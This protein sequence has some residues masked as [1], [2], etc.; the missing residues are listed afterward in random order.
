MHGKKTHAGG[1]SSEP[2]PLCSRDQVGV[3]EL[4]GQGGSLD[5]A[6]HPVIIR[7]TIDA[8]L[9]C[10]PFVNDPVAAALSQIDRRNTVELNEG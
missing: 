10:E 9:V 1:R 5:A 3:D 8:E 2:A 6:C 4:V 7:Q